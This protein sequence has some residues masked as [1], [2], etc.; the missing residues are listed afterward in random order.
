M[1]ERKETLGRAQDITGPGG[2]VGFPAAHSSS[3]SGA[4][5]ACRN[6]IR[7]LPCVSLYRRGVGGKHDN[8]Q[9]SDQSDGGGGG[10]PVC[11]LQ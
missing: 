1:G 4:R 5:P 2:P 6:L 8:S 3:T 10:P 7:N 9:R 11:L